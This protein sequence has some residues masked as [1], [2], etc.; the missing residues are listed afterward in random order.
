MYKIYTKNNC[1]YCKAAKIFL[2]SKGLQYVEFNIENVD[3]YK[4]ML[5]TEVPHAKSVPQIF[6]NDRYIGGYM[7]LVERLN[8]HDPSR[9]LTEART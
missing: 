9:Y 7:E 5:L 2:E 1:S 3:Y 6:E 4:E 8:N